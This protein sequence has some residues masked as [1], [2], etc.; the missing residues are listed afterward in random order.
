ME[1]FIKLKILKI[2]LYKVESFYVGNG[3]EI[4]HY[5]VPIA[6]IEM[7][8]IVFLTQSTQKITIFVY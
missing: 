7:D 8:L 2:G 1:C 5:Y 4:W 6:V 3:V